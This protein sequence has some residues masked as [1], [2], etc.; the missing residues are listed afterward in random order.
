MIQNNCEFEVLINGKPLK[1]YLHEGKTYVEGRKNTRFSLRLRNNSSQRKLF[2]P[3]IDGLSVM[4]G[5]DASFNSSGYIV[6]PYSSITIDGWRTSDSEVASFFFSAPDESYGA[7]TG[8]G[9]NLG[10][11]GLV[12]FDEKQKPQPVIIEKIIEKDRHHC[13]N[14][15]CG[16]CNPWYPKISFDS[17]MAGNTSTI[18]ALSATQTDSSSTAYSMRNVSQSL[19]TGFGES[20]RSEVVTVEF[21]PSTAPTAIFEIYYNTREQLEKMGIDLRKEALYVGRA[22][23]AFPG[24][25]CKPPTN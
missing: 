16:I 13:H 25:Y 6:R 8:K 4:D 1:E 19:G 9:Q 14:H 17:T 12:V 22:P 5:R 7:K 21:E 18:M 11:I 10:V 23:N 2:V 20:K 3:S 15:W 24:Q